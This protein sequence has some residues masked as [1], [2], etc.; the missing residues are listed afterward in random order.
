MRLLGKVAKARA[1]VVPKKDNGH[2]MVALELVRSRM[3]SPNKMEQPSPQ[4]LR[5]KSPEQ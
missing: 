2:A 1:T 5:V 4:R 3:A